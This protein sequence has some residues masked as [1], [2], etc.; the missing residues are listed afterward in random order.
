MLI[1]KWPNLFK[2]LYAKKRTRTCR[3]K[4][5]QWPVALRL[6]LAFRQSLQS[7]PGSASGWQLPCHQAGITL[8]W[9]CMERKLTLVEWMSGAEKQDQLDDYHEQWSINIIYA[10]ISYF[11]NENHWPSFELKEFSLVRSF[12]KDGLPAANVL[13]EVS[14]AFSAAVI[15]VDDLKQFTT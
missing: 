11:C 6:I 8:S 5:H 14:I 13:A 3:R 4:H 2:V 15:E 1:H 7:F 12:F 9:S 10:L